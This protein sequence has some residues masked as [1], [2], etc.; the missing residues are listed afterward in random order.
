MAKNKNQKKAAPRKFGMELP[1]K[2]VEKS[3][4]KPAEG[5]KKKK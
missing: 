3:K 4:D 5:A 1:K 2:P